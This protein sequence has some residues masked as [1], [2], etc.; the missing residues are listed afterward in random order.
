MDLVYYVYD[1]TPVG[2][3][4]AL[5]A[6]LRDGKGTEIRPVPVERFQPGLFAAARRIGTDQYSA[7]AFLHSLSARLPPEAWR[8][9]F[10]CFFTGCFFTGEPGVEAT[11][12][13]YLRLLLETGGRAADDWTDETVRRAQRISRRVGHEV[14]RLQ[15]FVRFEKVAG[16]PTPASRA[17]DSG[18]CGEAIAPY[19]SQGESGIPP[20][21][22]YARVEPDHAVLPLLA[23]HFAAR[24]ADQTWLI[25]DLRRNTGIHYD[26]R[27]WVYLPAVAIPAAG[28]GG[29][30][31]APDEDLYQGVWRGYFQA[32]AIPE[33]LNPSLQRQR[34]PG[35]YWG[36]MTEMRPK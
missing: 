1:G 8:G 17:D 2:L 9:L 4:N 29:L 18:G 14:H 20:A 26:G 10:Y 16:T 3:I 6:A 13:D 36:N 31:P 32:I 23:P 35:R 24:F 34:A 22:Y 21:L 15:G 11:L 19:G 7:G 12:L 5:A 28:G 27:R 33:R 30:Q 25:H